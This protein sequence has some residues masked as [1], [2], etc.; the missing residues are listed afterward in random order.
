LS[1]ENPLQ[2]GSKDGRTAK[3]T[4]DVSFYDNRREELAANRSTTIHFDSWEKASIAFEKGKASII[5]DSPLSGV[6]KDI[7]PTSPWVSKASSKSKRQDAKASE[8]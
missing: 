7:V 4:I 6:A 3:V 5:A 2:E 1:K 8:R